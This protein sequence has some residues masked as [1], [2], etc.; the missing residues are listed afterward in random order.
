MVRKEL[1]LFG[2]SFETAP[3]QY[4]LISL[5]SLAVREMYQARRQALALCGVIVYNLSP[6]VAEDEWKL[7][8]MGFHVSG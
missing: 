5:G 3:S 2:N 6:I 4:S 7:L 1:S 8:G